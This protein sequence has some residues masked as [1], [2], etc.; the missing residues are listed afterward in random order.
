MKHRRYT[1]DL[2]V[3]NV[4]LGSLGAFVPELVL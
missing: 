3:V 2:V 1:F 4:S